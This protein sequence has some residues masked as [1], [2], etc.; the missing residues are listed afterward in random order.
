LY[1]GVLLFTIG[2]SAGSVM[3]GFVLGKAAN[4]TH[5]EAT[6]VTLRNTGGVAITAMT[7]PLI[8][9]LLDRHW[10]GEWLTEGVRSFNLS[11][12]QYSLMVLPCYLVFALMLLYYVREIREKTHLAAPSMVQ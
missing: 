3:L 1:L 8:G 10:N 11:N 12:Y 6:L 9:Y 5:A 7:E 4:D 2:F